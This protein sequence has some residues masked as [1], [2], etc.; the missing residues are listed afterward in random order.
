MRP[1]IAQISRD[2]D[3]A[4]QNRQDV[5]VMLAFFI[6]IIALFPLAIGP[7]SAMLQ[8]LGIPM[9]WIGAMLSTLNGFD[10]LFA[11][12]VR[13][14]WLDQISLSALGLGWYALAKAVSHWLTSGLPLLLITPILALM[15]NI[16]ITRLPALMIALW[17][18]T[19]ALTL[20]G[21]IG[22]ALAEGA[23]RS[24]ALIALL[25]LPL[26]V[27]VLIFGALAAATDDGVIS[28]HLMLL[29]AMLALLLVIS[30]LV[31]AIALKIGET[32]SGI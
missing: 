27:P 6:I 2:L 1:F 5:V 30:P 9:I 13:D 19:M 26:T 22:A 20:L 24:N 15:L 32:E 31:A 23:R 4:W 8:S 11:Q 25:V 18:G 16:A 17:V 14:G 12:D 10:R 3:I 29:G 21:I 28:P 7:K